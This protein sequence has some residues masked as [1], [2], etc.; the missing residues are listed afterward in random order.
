MAVKRAAKASLAVSTGITEIS[1]PSNDLFVVELDKKAD[2]DSC[3][4]TMLS[5][6]LPTIKTNRL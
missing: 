2:G 5:R 3:A 1:G 6:G 4:K